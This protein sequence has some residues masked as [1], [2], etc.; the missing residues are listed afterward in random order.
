VLVLNF[1]PP[2]CSI[3]TGCK[4]GSILSSEHAKDDE[5]YLQELP[6]KHE[7]KCPEN[8]SITCSQN[9]FWG[10]S[11]LGAIQ[12]YCQGKK[13]EE[14]RRMV[15]KNLKSFPMEVQEFIRECLK[16]M[17]VP[18]PGFKKDLPNP[19]EYFRYLDLAYMS[20][21]LESAKLQLEKLK[22]RAGILTY[23][24]KV[25]SSIGR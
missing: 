12:S 13:P 18:M 5:I 21:G 15:I 4:H 10:A 19:S 3:P 20:G 9:V 16:S 24:E 8:E 1:V 14:L 22:N 2:E 17:W 25:R 11:P 7:I 23:E 6:I